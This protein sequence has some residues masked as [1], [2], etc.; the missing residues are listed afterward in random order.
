MKAKIVTLAAALLLIAALASACGNNNGNGNSNNGENE[1]KATNETSA[2]TTTAE[3]DSG[4]TVEIKLEAKDFE[5][6]QKEIHVKKGDHVKITLHSDDAGH[7]F[8]IAD[9]NVDIKGDGDGE[10]DAVNAGTFE[11]H[12]SVMCGSGH[13]DMVGKLIVDEA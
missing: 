11:F 2:N 3:P 5:Y 9:Y 7:G 4:S 13:R 1:S 8:S 12:C 10:F 6:D